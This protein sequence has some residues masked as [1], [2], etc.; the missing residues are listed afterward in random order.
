M[1][2]TTRYR[3]RYRHW[4][5]DPDYPHRRENDRGGGTY[6]RYDDRYYKVRKLKTGGVEV[7]D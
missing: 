6:Y 1:S 7:M 2:C 5:S 3:L 4:D